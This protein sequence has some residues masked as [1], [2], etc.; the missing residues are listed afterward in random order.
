MSTI[1]TAF[2]QQLGCRVP[3]IVAPMFLVSNVEMVVAGSEA[4]AVGSFP[5]LNARPVE[6]LRDWLQEIKARTQK[7][8]AVNIVVNRSNPYR[9]QHIDI[10]LEER[11]PMIIASLG[12]PAEL[13][14]RAHAVGTRV[15]C[16]VITPEHAQKAVDAGA[17]GL[18]AVSAGAGGHA[19]TIS[20][21]VW[22]PYLRKRFEVPII[23]AGGIADGA[24][25]AA[26]LALGAAG[27]QVGTRF[28]ASTECPVVPEYKQAIVK[29]SPFDVVTTYKLDGIP[30]NVLKTPYVEKTG[31]RQSWLERLLF[32][33]R[34][35]R[36]LIIT[37]RTLRSM[38]LLEKAAQRPTWKEL[39]GAGQVAGLIDD[40]EPI[41]VI[42]QRMVRQCAETTGRVRGMTLGGE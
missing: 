22:I 36:S 5:A 29:A 35:G 40:I 27:V 34:K 8:F 17:D 32:R 14:E 2:T 37:L 38:R 24:G 1:Q 21:F 20:P 6:K 33:S 15:Y 12:N 9:Q 25:M 23:A 3:V 4:G 30:A 39:W 16:D 13:I 11:V 19:G 10:C 7:P 26:A 18:I 31:T 28:I 41:A 42:L